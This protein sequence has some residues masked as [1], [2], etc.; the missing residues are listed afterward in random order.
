MS[1]TTEKMEAMAMKIVEL[2]EREGT[3]WVKPWSDAGS[4][5]NVVSKKAYRGMNIL[6]LG[7]AASEAEY[8]SSEWATFK[9]WS[10]KG[11]KVKKGQKGTDIFFFSRMIKKD[12]KTNKDKFIGFWKYYTVFNADQVDGYESPTKEQTEIASIESVDSY[13]SNTGATI[14]HAGNRAYYSPSLD[15]IGMPNKTDFESVEGYYSTLL[16]ELAHWTGHSSRLDRIT[17][18]SKS[19]EEYAKEE[20]VAECG[21]AFLCTLLGVTREPTPNHAKYLNAWIR[22]IKDN[23]KTLFTA[24]SKAQKVVDFLEELQV[25][26]KDKLA[27]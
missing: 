25:E 20:L 13:V 19:N 8:K 22:N 14:R 5:H 6:S 21:S 18:T 11:A 2:M 27:A 7:L 9:Q 1:K 15:F 4:A 12:E 24:I 16:H 10:E 23:P 17:S 26:K 3:N